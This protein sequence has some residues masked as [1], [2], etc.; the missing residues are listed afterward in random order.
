M[1]DLIRRTLGEQI[2]IETVLAGGLWRT[3][4][5]ANQL[6]VALLNLVINGRDAMPEGG[7][8]TVESAN[9]HL[10]QAYADQHEEVAPGQYVM[11][12]VTDTGTGMSKEI[13]ER[14]FDPFFTTKA[15]GEGTGLG[16][17]MVYGFVKQSGGHI[18]IYSEPGHGTS[19]KIYLPR[20]A[21]EHEA[22]APTRSPPRRLSRSEP[23]RVAPFWWSRTSRTCGL[24]PCRH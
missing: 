16:L 17:S 4:C 15:P 22:A 18:K 7:K 2:A 13:I 21:D 19:I 20:L 11:V 12:A 3:R 24:S 6:E 23:P 14:A 5:D 8:L 10:D 9:A 1:S